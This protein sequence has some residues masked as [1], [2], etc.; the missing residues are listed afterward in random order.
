MS[1]DVFQRL[2]RFD[3][4]GEKVHVPCPSDFHGLCSRQCGSNKY[5]EAVWK[6]PDCSNCL[7]IPLMEIANKPGVILQGRGYPLAINNA[8]CIAKTLLTILENRTI[9]YLP[10]EVFGIINILKTIVFAYHNP[11]DLYTYLG[12]IQHLTS[13]SCSIK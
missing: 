9:A 10:D 7:Y 8:D 12:V 6:P 13:S 4:I 5:E 3:M 11:V 1:V 2:A